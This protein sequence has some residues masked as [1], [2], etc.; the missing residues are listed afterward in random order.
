[1]F[2]DMEPRIYSHEKGYIW[3]FFVNLKRRGGVGGW[4]RE[5]EVHFVSYPKV[6]NS[7]ISLVPLLFETLTKTSTGPN[8]WQL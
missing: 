6:C 3:V 4:N 7:Y 5:K 8:T 1:M 2:L